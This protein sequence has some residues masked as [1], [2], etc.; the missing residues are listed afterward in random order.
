MK[1]ASKLELL[2]LDAISDDTE[3]VA[4]IWYHNKDELRNI[5]GQELKNTIYELYKRGL[6]YDQSVTEPITREDILS[7]ETTNQYLTGNYYFGLTPSGVDYWEKLSEQSGYPVDWSDSWTMTFDSE[8]QEGH[9]DG[10]SRA[11]CLNA[12]K[13]VDNLELDMN[14]LLDSEINGFLAKYYKYVSGGHRITFR[15]RKR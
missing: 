14:T 7:Q 6:I 15:Y 3:F 1:R 13:K 11:V 9:V 10:T 12:L 8:R 5:S 2:I 4:S